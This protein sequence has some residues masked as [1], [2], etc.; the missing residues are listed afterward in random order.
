MVELT[1]GPLPNAAKSIKPRM[2][3]SKSANEETGAGDKRDKTT[4]EQAPKRLKQLEFRY[5]SVLST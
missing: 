1:R 3:A 5:L 4:G 2:P